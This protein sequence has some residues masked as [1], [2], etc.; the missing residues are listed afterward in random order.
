LGRSTRVRYSSSWIVFIGPGCGQWYIATGGG[1]RIGKELET[2]VAL[3]A[4]QNTE[5]M[6]LRSSKVV[7]NSEIDITYTVYKVTVLEKRMRLTDE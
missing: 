5:N 2:R 7:S 4:F 3:E 1:I 6:S